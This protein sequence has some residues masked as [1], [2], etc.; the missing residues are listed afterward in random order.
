MRRPSRET[1]VP[2][3]SVARESAPAW[4]SN[5]IFVCPRI[6]FARA[7]PSA[8]TVTSTVAAKA[9]PAVTSTSPLTP[10]IE[11]DRTTVT[12]PKVSV[13]LALAWSRS[14]R[15][16]HASETTRKAPMRRIQRR[17]RPRER[18]RGVSVVIVVSV[19]MPV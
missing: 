14:A 4:F 3:S 2:G 16:G 7:S 8:F 13:R 5:E 12:P 19:L 1:V 6:S 17:V 15:A 11:S 9:G 10:S 18:D